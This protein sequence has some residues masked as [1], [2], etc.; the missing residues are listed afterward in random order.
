VVPVAADLSRLADVDRLLERATS[1]FP[2]Y[3]AV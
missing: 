3:A 2:L 1:D